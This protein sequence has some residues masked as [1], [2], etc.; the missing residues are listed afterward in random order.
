MGL[1]KIQQEIHAHTHSRKFITQPT[2][3]IEITNATTENTPN[4]PT[5]KKIYRKHISTS[6]SRRKSL[7]N[8]W[9]TVRN[10]QENRCLCS[11]GI[12]ASACQKK[13]APLLGRPTFLSS[14]SPILL[15]PSSSN[16]KRESGGH[17][18]LKERGEDEK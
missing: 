14:P 5:K 4:R 16:P 11:T 9:M 8:R 1:S 2:H 17:A 3:T 7:F 10:P 13:S 18:G 12:S 15:L 6:G